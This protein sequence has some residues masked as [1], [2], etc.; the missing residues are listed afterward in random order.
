MKRA[1]I[2]GL[3]GLFF[4]LFTASLVAG[5]LVFIGVLNGSVELVWLTRTGIVLEVL[6]VGLIALEFLGGARHRVSPSRWWLRKLL[7]DNR[8]P[9]ISLAWSRHSI[10]GVSGV[11]LLA[12][13]LLQLLTRW[14]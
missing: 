2:N 4:N 11:A 1:M 5:V 10:L 7:H 8:G 13:L 3:F 9:G 12:G 14:V 6:G